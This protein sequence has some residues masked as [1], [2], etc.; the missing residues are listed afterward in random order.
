MKRILI[1][2]MT[3]AIAIMPVLAA[4][5]EQ[6]GGGTPTGNENVSEN[7]N[8][9]GDQSVSGSLNGTGDQIGSE[10]QNVTSPAGVEEQNTS[11]AAL[12]ADGAGDDVR[13]MRF[14]LTDEAKDELQ[15]MLSEQEGSGVFWIEP[16]RC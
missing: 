9:T 2:I 1:C 10:E 8:S 5:G 3:L 12:T 16:V 13:Q 11:D 7:L 15:T 4:C 6:S 14:D